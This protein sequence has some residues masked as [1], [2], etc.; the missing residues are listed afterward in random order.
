[1]LVVLFCVIT[2]TFVLVRL[3]PGGPFTKERSIKPEILRQLEA[4]FNLDGSLWDQYTAY[5]GVRKNNQGKFSGLLQGNFQV[6]TRMLNR[7]VRDLLVQT[8][9][10][11][12]T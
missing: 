5:L 9:P 8:L 6:S 10:V 4:N 2:I 3:A 1:M 11:S 12:F 7:S